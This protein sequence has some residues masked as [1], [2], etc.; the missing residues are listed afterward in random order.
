MYGRLDPLSHSSLIDLIAPGAPVSS[1]QV[2]EAVK[3]V[4]SL[5]F[6]ARWMGCLGGSFL[7]SASDRE[8][9]QHI[10]K[11]LALRD[12]QAIWCIRGGYGS[13]RLMSVLGRM[14]KPQR[15]KIFI[16]YSDVSI[17]QMF[18]NLSWGWPALHFPVLTQLKDCSPSAVRRFQ[19]ILRGEKTKQVFKKLKVF[20]PKKTLKR[21][22]SYVVGGNMTLVQSS[23]GTPWAYSFKNKILFLEDTGESP[24]RVDRTLWQMYHA[25]VF[26]G[27]RALILGDFIGLKKGEKSQMRKVFQ[28]FSSL[29]SFPILEGIPCGH[30]RKKEALPFMTNCEL[31]IKRGAQAELCIQ[32][33]FKKL[34]KGV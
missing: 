5:G 21:I 28:S 4:E 1:N 18:L 19:S 2:R 31:T 23:I 25:G 7:F 3:Q 12:S 26:K 34:P 30:G 33:P 8:R 32:S 14:K 13:Q 9:I 20:N 11:V 29:V 10:K 17:L 27:V 15:A 24:Y 22:R 16:G 6:R